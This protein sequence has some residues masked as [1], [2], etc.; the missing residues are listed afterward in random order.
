MAGDWF[1]SVF[2]RTLCR[3]RLQFPIAVWKF[4][5]ASSDPEHNSTRLGAV[6]AVAAD[7]NRALC[8]AYFG[9]HCSD[10]VVEGARQFHFYGLYRPE[11][12]GNQRAMARVSEG[13]EQLLFVFAGRYVW[14][15]GAGG[16]NACRFRCPRLGGTSRNGDEC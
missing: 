2:V 16:H 6:E 13:G 10:H 8:A 1:R 9:F 3:C 5:T 4:P 15:I 14:A 12:G 11:P 7:S